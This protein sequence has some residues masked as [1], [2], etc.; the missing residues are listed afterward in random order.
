M[1]IDFEISKK[2]FFFLEFYKL[3]VIIFFFKFFYEYFLNVVFFVF[4]LLYI[5]M[6]V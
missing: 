2:N 4:R 3:K 1:D 5:F 6:E